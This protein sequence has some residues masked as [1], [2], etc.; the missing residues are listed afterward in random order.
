MRFQSVVVS[1]F[2]VRP[3]SKRWFSKTIQVAME[4]VSI[5]CHVGIHVDFT[6]ILHSLAPLVDP[7]NQRE[8]FEVQWTHA[9][10][11]R[12]ALHLEAGP[13][14]CVR[15]LKSSLVID[16]KAQIGPN[17]FTPKGHADLV[18]W[19]LFL[20][21]CYD[22]ARARWIGCTQNGGPILGLEANVIFHLKK[23]LL[24]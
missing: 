12:A 6:S 24:K 5:W 9:L 16:Q 14:C 18:L 15:G 17:P 1:R 10:I 7:F 8:C 19:I 4:H 22:T 11:L 20:N 3:T 21:V 2:C 13:I 23:R